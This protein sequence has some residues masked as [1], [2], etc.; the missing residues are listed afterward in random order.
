MGFRTT[1]NLR[2]YRVAL[3]PMYGIFIILS[4]LSKLDVRKKFHLAVFEIQALNAKIKGV[5]GRS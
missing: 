4:C 3:N 5:F 1:L 2:K